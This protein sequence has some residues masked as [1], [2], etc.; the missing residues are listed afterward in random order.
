[1]PKVI[2][3]GSA[4]MDFTIAVDRLPAA[5]ETVLG[6]E[7]YQ[8]YGGKGANQAIAARR[9]GAD[10]VFLTKIGTDANGRL[11]EKHFGSSGLPPTGSTASWP[12]TTSRG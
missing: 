12:M 10:V 7:F 3:I 4:N 8:S 9:A 6:R 2:V 1:M 5:G 11:M